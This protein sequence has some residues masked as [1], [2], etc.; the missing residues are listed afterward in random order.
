MKTPQINLV[1]KITM[2]TKNIQILVITQKIQ[3][4]QKKMIDF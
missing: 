1:E 4:V 3:I 2:N